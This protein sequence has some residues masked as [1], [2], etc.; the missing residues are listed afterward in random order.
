MAA[1]KWPRSGWRTYHAIMAARRFQ[2]LIEWDPDDA[3][4]VTYVPELGHLST[5]GDTGEEAL[6]QTREAVMGYL[7]AA[8]SS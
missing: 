2:V 4:W 6:A 3:V 7:E 1:S 8:A 5:Y